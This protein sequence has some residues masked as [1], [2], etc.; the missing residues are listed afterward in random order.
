[1]C[2]LPYSKQRQAAWCAV[3]NG[4]NGYWEWKTH[5]GYDMANVLKYL[6]IASSEFDDTVP[7]IYSIINWQIA[8]RIVEHFKL[9]TTIFGGTL[10]ENEALERNYLN[11]LY[12]YTSVL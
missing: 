6:G 9:P 2:G 5:G 12:P 3:S 7:A 1:M 10:T 8:E 11:E 4:L